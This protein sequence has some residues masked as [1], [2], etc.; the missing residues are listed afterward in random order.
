MH[1]PTDNTAGKDCG[2]SPKMRKATDNL[3]MGVPPPEL[4]GEFVR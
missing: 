3:A 2:I 1:A 4:L